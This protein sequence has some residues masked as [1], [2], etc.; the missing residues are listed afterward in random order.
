[1]NQPNHETY[2]EA[3][4]LLR[5]GK[6][7]HAVTL[8]RAWLE[9][10]PEDEIGLSIFGSALLKLGS[11]TD[12]ISTFR[13]AVVAHPESFAA[14]GDLGFALMTSG[15]KAEAI[16]ALKNAVGLNRNF[17][18]GWCYLGRLQYETGALAEAKLSFDQAGVHDPFAV[19][20]GDIQTTLDSARLAAAEKIARRILSRQR[21]HPV[22]S[23]AL[24]RLATSV[25]ALEQ[26]A[27]ILSVAVE[28]FPIDLSLRAALI[29]SL[30]ETGDY[31]R[32]LGEARTAATL[33]PDDAIRWLAVGRIHGHCGQY[34]EALA[35]YDHAL[36]RTANGDDV[37]KG[38]LQLLRGHI[39]KI[40]G[41]HDES[42]LAYR[43]SA[44]SVPGNGAAWWGLADL[45]TYRFGDDDVEQMQLI[46][47][48][49]SVKP[50]Q[51]CQAAFA[52]GKVLEDRGHYDQAFHSY[53][54][55]NALRPD[56][57][58]N[59]DDFVRGIDEIIAEFTPELLRHQADPAPAGATPIFVIGLPRSGS[60][61][62]EQILASHSAIEGTMELVNLPNLL[63]RIRIDG[64]R[65]KISYPR[66]MAGFA[67]AE[68]STYG[69]AY[70]DGTKMYRSDK[71][72][73]IDKMPTNF[74]KVGLIHMILPSAVIIDARRRPLDCGF[75]CFK[76]H[77]AGG[78]NFSYRLENVAH[79]Y[80][81]YLKLMDHWDRV[82]PGKVLCVQYEQL[83]EQTEVIV[84][85]L[86]EHCGLPF[87]AQCLQFFENVRPVRT[88][89]SEQ[90]RQP[91][92]RKGVDHWKNF[93]A[94]LRPLADALGPATLERFVG[95]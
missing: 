51:R 55:A 56:V 44:A 8:I 74:D 26:A 94:H 7:D 76:Q 19:E 33:D 47:S 81:G 64:G 41:R 38:N 16:E 90:V 22:A 32:A 12:A 9:Q 67:A 21:G 24:A 40:L 77:F 85:A 69:Q 87:E 57:E 95:R 91:I 70:I 1:M 86:L 80:N 54:E 20:C 62:I 31:D 39:L 58:F 11:T 68:L 36:G 42:V 79:Y 63:R 78:H 6:A 73:F 5:S 25:G 59:A 28:N 3:T 49:D 66:S 61:L 50:A 71:P 17:Y 43:A 14:H 60:T 2:R 72:F 15:N 88:A 89:S 4:Q 18:Q 34:A 82:M 35:A 75:S 13:K 84:R 45:K 29:S 93:E 52:L 10:H 92:Y 65:R 83:V 37:A 48:A 23:L 27:D 53:E 30:E 46:A